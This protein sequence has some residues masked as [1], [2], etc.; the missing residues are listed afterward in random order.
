MVKG[1][2]KFKQYFAPHSDSFIVIG[3]TAMQLH[4]REGGPVPRVTQNIGFRGSD[5]IG[6]LRVVE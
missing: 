5:T 1:F 4:G 2:D 3:G 6:G